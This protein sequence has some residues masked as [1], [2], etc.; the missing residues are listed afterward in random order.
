MTSCLCHIIHACYI[1]HNNRIIVFLVCD[2]K[3]KYHLTK[4]YGRVYGREK[5]L[6]FT[7]QREIA[8]VAGSGVRLK[9]HL[10]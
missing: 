1:P 8:R 10:S 7:Y 6:T 4:V 3:S 2:G 9:G 5:G